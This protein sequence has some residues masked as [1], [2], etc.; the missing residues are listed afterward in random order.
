MSRTNKTPTTTISASTTPVDP[1]AQTIR[2]L[3]APANKPTYA[4]TDT[5]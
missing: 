3:G 5:T 2:L 1:V 4:W